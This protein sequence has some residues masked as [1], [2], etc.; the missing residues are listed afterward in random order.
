MNHA[1]AACNC[2]YA[3]AICIHVMSLNNELDVHFSGCSTAG[4]NYHKG[5][6]RDVAHL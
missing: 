6:E 3:E 1:L 4:Q 5:G 2:M